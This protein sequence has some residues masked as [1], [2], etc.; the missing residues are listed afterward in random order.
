MVESLQITR[1]EYKV[2]DF[3]EWQRKGSLSLDPPFQRRSVWKPGAKSYLVD[4]VTRGLPIPIVFV[5]ERVDLSR[6]QALREV[7]DGQQRLRTLIGFIDPTALSDFDQGRDGFT[8]R[9]THNP[10]LADKTFGQLPDDVQRQI[11]GYEISTHI[12]PSIMDDKAILQMFARL[13]STGVR[14]NGQEL[15]NANWFGLCKTAMYELSY[16]QLDR[17]RRWTVF[18]DDDISR[19]KEV[20]FVSDVALNIVSGLS[21]KSQ[22]KL[23]RFYGDYDERFPG[24]RVLQRRVGVLFDTIDDLLGHTIAQ[25]A[26]NSEVNFFTLS[27]YLYDR[28]YGLGSRLD[29]TAPRKVPKSLM[30]KLIEV[31]QKIRTGDVPRNVLDAIQRASADL[32]RRQTRLAFMRTVCGGASSN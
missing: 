27:A 8:V 13:N 19:M 28:L 4:T 22:P 31:S 17:W 3:L 15:R 16:E 29:K 20:E 6:Q 10:Q 21:G 12:L 26:Y 30:A 9:K 7:V 2:S 32:G 5:R 14:L 18:S 25:S 23:D 11:L 1:S 24:L